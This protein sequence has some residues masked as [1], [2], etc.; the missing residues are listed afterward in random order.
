[1]E[2]I[3]IIHPDDEIHDKLNYILGNDYHIE[4]F[5]RGLNAYV[6]MQSGNKPD[7][8]ITNDALSDVDLREVLG[9]LKNSG[10]YSDIPV[11]VLSSS[12]GNKLADELVDAGADDCIYHPIDFELV[13]IAVSNILLK[14]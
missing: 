4:S 7:L 8:V 10:F 2:E 13:K 5:N 9:S 6:W 14:K 1:M 3:I 11:L 12:P